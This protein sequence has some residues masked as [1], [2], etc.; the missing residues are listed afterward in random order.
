MGNAR[1]NRYSKQHK[2][3]STHGKEFWQYSWH[4]IGVLDLP[5]MIDYVQGTTNQ[6]KL[7][8]IGHSQVYSS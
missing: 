1:G 8:Y 4:E 5:T 3:F 2:L 7:Q 6:E